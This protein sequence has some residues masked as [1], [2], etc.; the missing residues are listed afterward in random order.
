[1]IRPGGPRR[2]P[3]QRESR[4]APADGLFARRARDMR[5]YRTS[6]PGGVMAVED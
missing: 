5:P 3:H 4:K 1:M 6:F 2:R